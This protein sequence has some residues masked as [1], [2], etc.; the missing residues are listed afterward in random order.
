M[1]R[2]FSVFLVFVNFCLVG[3]L[4]SSES[5]ALELKWDEDNTLFR[6]SEYRYENENLFPRVFTTIVAMPKSFFHLDKDEYL[7]SAGFAVPVIAFMLPLEDPYDAK[8]QRSINRNRSRSLDLFFPNMSTL[9]FT[10]GVAGISALAYGVGHYVEEPGL[11]EFGSLYL[12]GLAAAQIM[13]SVLKLGTGREGPRDGSTKGKM[14]GPTKL[15]YP[16]GTPSG[17]I[18]TYYYTAYLTAFYFDLYWLE[19]LGHLGGLYV[20]ASLV[21]N[22]EHFISDIFW[23]APMGYYAAKWM[24]HH[25]SSKYKYKGRKNQSSSVYVGPTINPVF[26]STE[27]SFIYS[28]K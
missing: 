17:H 13:H 14:Y 20:G 15:F 5:E 12:E 9:D 3:S 27:L 6:G 22:N 24:M 19:I 23:G 1:L 28:Y 25:R 7:L 4:K 18:L 16:Y 8:L 10:L 2:F 21:Y 11:K 26:G